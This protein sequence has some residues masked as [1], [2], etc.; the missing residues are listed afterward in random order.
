M[1]KNARLAALLTAAI[2]ALTGCASATSTTSHQTS[3]ALPPALQM[4]PGMV[5][6]D[7]STMGADAKSTAPTTKPAA[8]AA[9][10]P[11][12]AAKMV[13]SDEIRKAVSAVLALTSAPA[14]HATWV[15]HK[16]TCTY[17]LPMGEFVL[18]VKESATLPAAKAYTDSVRTGLAGAKAL[19]GLTD[20]AFGT[21]GGVVILLKDN[22]TLS[23]DA[24]ALPAQFGD[25]HQKRTD[26]A[27]EIAS[28]ILG[29]WTGND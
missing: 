22:D 19:A 20:T 25:Q 21:P 2:V 29:C 9:G 11:S 4:T 23:V 26:F 13:C 28:D 7:G 14:T 10:A 27:Y 1:M 8:A 15:E 18:S 16:Y 5:M 6:A 17:H 24:S 12:A 3:S